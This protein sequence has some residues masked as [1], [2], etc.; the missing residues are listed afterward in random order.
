[1]DI[2][3][4]G[5]R[6][7]ASAFTSVTST[8]NQGSGGEIPPPSLLIL[9]NGAQGGKTLLLRS[10]LPSRGS[11]GLRSSLA[12]RLYVTRARGGSPSSLAPAVGGSCFYV[13]FTNMKRSKNILGG[14]TS[15]VLSEK[16]PTIVLLHIHLVNVGVLLHKLHRLLTFVQ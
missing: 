5:K 1:M 11:G 4:W 15:S 8:P 9:Y 14:S 7:H 12:P 2:E 16:R 3:T 10:A 6:G 13:R